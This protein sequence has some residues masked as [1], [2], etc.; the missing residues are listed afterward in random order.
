M[1]TY[2]YQ[3]LRCKKNYDLREG[4]SAEVTHT[5]QRCGKG[6]AKRVLHA[7]RVVFKGSGFYAT[8]SRN[9]SAALADNASSDS[10][11]AATVEPGAKADA[12]A[13]STTNESAEAAPKKEPVKAQA[14]P[15]SA[16]SDKAS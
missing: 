2:E 10:G 14:K 13:P 9:K 16:G 11:D 15:A 12:A 5:C 7:P 8:D 1:P 4:F 6:T 3:C